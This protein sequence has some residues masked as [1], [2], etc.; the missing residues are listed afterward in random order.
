MENIRL[1][2]DKYDEEFEPHL[3][4]FAQAIWALLMK[5]RPH[6]TLSAQCTIHE[7]IP[8]KTRGMFLYKEQYE[9]EKN[10]FRPL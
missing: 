3:R 10:F 2:T 9:T 4:K 7:S 5:V 1:Y 6:A 8:G